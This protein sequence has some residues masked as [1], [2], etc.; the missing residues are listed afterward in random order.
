MVFNE[1]LSTEISLPRILDHFVKSG[2]NPDIIL[3]F[4]ELHEDKISDILKYS[5]CSPRFLSLDFVKKLTFSQ[6]EKLA[7]ILFNVNSWEVD[8]LLWQ[9]F[10][11]K[12]LDNTTKNIYNKII[13]S[14][15]PNKWLSPYRGR[16]GSEV[17]AFDR[18]FIDCV[19]ASDYVV[20]LGE[21][22]ND[23][24]MK[25]LKYMSMSIVLPRLFQEDVFCMIDPLRQFVLLNH[26]PEYRDY[27][28]D[29]LSRMCFFRVL[30]GL[31]QL[32][33]GNIEPEIKLNICS[34]LNKIDFRMVGTDFLWDQI[35]DIVSLT[36]FNQMAMKLELKGKDK[37]CDWIIFYLL[38][39]YG[40]EFLKGCGKGHK[41]LFEKH[42]DI[43]DILG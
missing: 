13:T 43:T 5:D 28:R 2:E 37:Y 18:N 32:V 22:S 6:N 21:L 38:C 17:L 3:N 40:L 36:S 19:D 34:V 7:R 29:D 10:L 25:Y 41:Y 42:F 35:K 11:S 14:Y 23:E 24:I 20:E 4:L 8:C 1:N 33:S 30:K 31:K 12:T 16:T 39:E 15:P 26:I 27:P 9:V